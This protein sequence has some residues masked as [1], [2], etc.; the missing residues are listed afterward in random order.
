MDKRAPFTKLTLILL[1]GMFVYPLF[2]DTTITFKESPES[3]KIYEGNAV[4]LVCQQEREKLLSISRDGTAIVKN[5]ALVGS[6][7]KYSFNKENSSNKYVL[8]IQDLDKSDDGI[9]FCVEGVT[10]IKQLYLEILYPPKSGPNCS[11]SYGTSKSYFDDISQQRFYF[12]CTVEDGN[13]QIKFRLY[14][15]GKLRERI[16]PDKV[17]EIKQPGQ[18][19]LKTLMFSSYL[20]SSFNNS[21]LTCVVVQDIPSAFLGYDFNETCYFG[22]MRLLPTFDILI[23]P[24][25][26]SFQEGDV[27]VLTCSS[28]VSNVVKRWRNIPE[29]LVYETV[30]DKSGLHLKIFE[31]N[32]ISNQPIIL[33]CECLLGNRR[34]SA[35]ATIYITRN[36]SIDRTAVSF[37][38]ILGL[39]I[40]VIF[41][42]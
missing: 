21:R 8:K 34:L 40:A 15:D 27:K 37:E 19:L 2:P 39:G 3:Y 38:I 33:G 30:E 9:Y 1:S 29:G 25:N 7:L 42:I 5:L 20:N 13:P 14:K 35:E 12:N 31:M 17:I 23:T 4:Q 10:L 16:D 18:T 22:P 41:L 28:N 24:S 6:P 26:V 11:S 32:T 36:D